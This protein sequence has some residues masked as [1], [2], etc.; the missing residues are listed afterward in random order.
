MPMSEDFRKRLFIHLPEIIK[1]F[2]TPFHIY[3]EMGI[4]ETGENLKKH[5]PRNF[6]EYYAVKANPNPAIL[7]MML[8]MRFGFDCSS[9]PE[10]KLVRH[11]GAPPDK[12]MFSSNNTTCEEFDEALAYGG[13]ILNLDDITMIDKIPV[14]PELICFRYNPG[15]RRSEG[16][17]FIIGEPTEQKYGV[18]HEDIVR[19]YNLAKRRGG[20]RFG[21]HTMI[22]SN[23]MDFHYLVETVK[24]L[25]EVI[26]MVSKKLG[27]KFEFINMGGG[28]GTPYK[29]GCA[30]FDLLA[31]S[32]GIKKLMVNFE[33]K[34]SYKPRLFMESG[35]YMAGPHGV[36][37]TKCINVLHKYKEF[38]G[39]DASGPPNLM[40]AC[41]YD[42]AHHE[43]TIY[44]KGDD[45][46][47]EKVSIVGALCE[48]NDQLAK[49][50]LLPKIEDG[51][52]LIIHNTGAHGLAMGSNYNGR[53][54]CQEL[55]L[56]KDGSVEL[57]RR[58]ETYEDYIKTLIFEPKILKGGM[59]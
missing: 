57:V 54:K 15:I 39:V 12:I 50:R 30:D 19:A 41:I 58:A 35:R 20:K 27:I 17:N 36:I 26:R 46:I 28:I 48:N 10:L 52:I 21:I 45:V 7:K 43:I 22:C 47:K 56:R 29:F 38:R 34:H 40:R 32:K 8:N 18:P 37:V 59:I 24:M 9:I 51:D 2:G 4:L 6:M 53:L 5:L 11:F 49:D 55:M 31:M 3:D 23:Q 13:C 16:S 33:K 42:S 44:G 14:M 1:V 25:L